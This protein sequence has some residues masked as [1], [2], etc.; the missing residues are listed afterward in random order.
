MGASA[1]KHEAMALLK[2]ECKTQLAESKPKL[3]EWY[4]QPQK[5]LS[6]RVTYLAGIRPRNIAYDEKA[7][8]ARPGQ[9]HESTDKANRESNNDQSTHN[10]HEL[11]PWT[12][13]GKYIMRH[14]P[15]TNLYHCLPEH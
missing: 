1:D 7:S 11:W 3:G 4:G 9:S 13:P 6:Q 14:I 8:V 2:L 15:S 12:L 10:S 5:A